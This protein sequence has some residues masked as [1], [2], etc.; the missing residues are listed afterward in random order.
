MSDYKGTHHI[1]INQVKK[2]N[3]A[4]T[5]KPPLPVTLLNTILSLPLRCSHSLTF[6]VVISLLFIVLL[7]A[8]IPK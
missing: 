5:Q 3:I 1:T 6:V 4:S 7:Q 8:Y 2:W